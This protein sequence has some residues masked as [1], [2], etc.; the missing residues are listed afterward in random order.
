MNIFYTRN[1]WQEITTFLISSNPIEKEAPV[2][3]AKNV[4][5]DCQLVHLQTRWQSI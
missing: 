1:I 3:K 4:E 2:N 5:N